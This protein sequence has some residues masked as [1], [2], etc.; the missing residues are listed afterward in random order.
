LNFRKLKGLKNNHLES[1]RTKR[2]FLAL[3]LKPP[4]IFSIFS[5]MILIL[6]I[7]LLVYKSIRSNCPSILQQKN[8]ID[9]KKCLV[10]KMKK[11][12]PLKFTMICE[13]VNNIV[14]T[15]PLSLLVFSII[16]I[17]IACNH[18]FITDGLNEK[19]Q[20]TNKSLTNYFCWWAHQ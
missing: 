2:N 6:S 8:S 10:T 4:P 18:K 20:I 5:T 9:E 19:Q 7:L 14:F 15:K 3:I 11:K 16:S 13:Y 12:I 1:R 17:N